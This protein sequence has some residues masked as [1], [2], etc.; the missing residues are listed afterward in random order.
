MHGLR[1]A[2]FA[3]AG[4]LAAFAACND[5]VTDPATINSFGA[6]LF[7]MAGENTGGGNATFTYDGA[8]ITFA[9]HFEG[10]STGPTQA[11]IHRGAAAAQTG[12]VLTDLCGPAAT[13]CPVGELAQPDTPPFTQGYFGDITGV[14]TQANMKPGM[15]LDGLVNDMRGF[16]AFVDLHSTTNPNGELRGNIVGVY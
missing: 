6:T 16:G 2:S 12:A 8:Q 9:V 10:L 11:H 1:T 15:T 3:A 13:A 14:I 7:T 5:D 4:V